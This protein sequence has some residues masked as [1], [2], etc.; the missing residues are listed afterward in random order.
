MNIDHSRTITIIA[1]TKAPAI[2]RSWSLSTKYHFRLAALKSP[3]LAKALYFAIRLIS[4]I[5][6]LSFVLFYRCNLAQPLHNLSSQGNLS[7]EHFYKART[8][9]ACRTC[10]S[11]SI[12]SGLYEFAFG[13][14]TAIIPHI[15]HFD[16]AAFFTKEHTFDNKL[17]CYLVHDNTV[18]I[19][20]WMWV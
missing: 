12:L 5:N 16:H 11:P 7:Q 8:W 20:R 18:L 17:P 6:S 19:S 14:A 1:P 4:S 2:A 3:M 9:A 10:N 15:D 13:Q